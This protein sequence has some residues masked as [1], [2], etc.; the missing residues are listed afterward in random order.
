MELIKFSDRIWYYPYESERDRP[1]LCYVRGDNLALAIDAGHSEAHLKEFYHALELK[2]L[3]LPSL[4]VLTHW[5]WDHSFAMHA[6]NG[7]C[8]A[9]RKTNEYLLNFKEE[10]KE[11]GNEFFLNMHDTIRKEYAS[12]QEVIVKEADIIFE[13]ELFLEL[14]NCPIKLMQITSPH[15]DDSTVIQVMN[16][17]VLFIG[18]AN[19]GEFPT[20]VKDKELTERF[21]DEL[22]SIDVDMCIEGHW[23]PDTKQGIIDEVL[24]TNI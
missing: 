21:V 22:S 18:D 4:T 10:L 24:S 19:G 20:W 7:L 11:K 9:N 2:G 8:I 5:H 13:G 3:P 16:E 23:T 6:V 14:G 15:T 1:N 12:G 17:R